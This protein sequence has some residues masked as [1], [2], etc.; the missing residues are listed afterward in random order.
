MD[1]STPASSMTQL[2]QIRTDPSGMRRLQM[3]GHN[4][5]GVCGSSLRIHLRAFPV[6]GRHCAD[7][8]IGDQKEVKSYLLFFPL[9]RHFLLAVLT[10]VLLWYGNL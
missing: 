10:V 9:D 7:R 6:A 1:D 4:F 8:A 3:A 5:S 2:K